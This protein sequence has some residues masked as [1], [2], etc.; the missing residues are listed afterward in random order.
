MNRTTWHRTLYTPLPTT[1]SPNDITSLLQNHLALI[2][3]SPLVTSCEELQTDSSSPSSSEELSAEEIDS[4]KEAKTYTIQERIPLVLGLGTT[5]SFT[6]SFSNVP[7]G[8]DT[9]LHAPLGLVS[10]QQCRVLR[11]EE[12]RRDAA[13]GV[14]GHDAGGGGGEVRDANGDEISSEWVFRES[15]ESEVAL[16]L[17]WY[18]DS[19]LV[20]TR[21]EIAARMIE[22]VRRDGGVTA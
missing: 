20:K 1:I 7:D 17:K 16:A 8:I 14:V 5:I 10:K 13:D 11:T 19:T 3:L 15:V 22:K 18:V 6:A 12:A 2:H 9:V 4:S 21:R